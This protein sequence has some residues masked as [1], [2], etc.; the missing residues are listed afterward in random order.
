MWESLFTEDITEKLGVLHCISCWSNYV[1]VDLF[2]NG[3]PFC[4]FRESSTD[5]G[6]KK[7]HLFA[8][9]LVLKSQY[10][11][12]SRVGVRLVA[13]TGSPFRDTYET[14]GK[15]HRGVI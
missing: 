8:L 3:F 5:L 11:Y 10:C 1:K 9:Q 14:Q 6:G 4:A 15:T 12:R 7:F 13:R 2:R